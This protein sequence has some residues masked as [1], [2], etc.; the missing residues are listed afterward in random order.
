MKL[1]RRPNSADLRDCAVTI[2]S[3]DGV[4]RGHQALIT[5]VLEH[6]RQ[7]GL[8]AVMMSFEPLPREVV[9][10]ADPPARLTNFRERWRLL[11]HSTLDFLWLL[12]FT[13]VRGRSAEEFMQLLAAVRARVVVVGHDFRFGRG[14]E[15]DAQWCAAQAPRHGFEV[16]ILPPVLSEGV[17]ISSDGVRAA[18][19]NADFAAARELLGRPYVMR[20]RVRRGDQLGRQLGFPTANIAV[21]RRRLALSGIFAV[22]V[23]EGGHEGAAPPRP[24]VASLG[25]RP[26]IGGRVPLLEAHLFDFDGDLYGRELEIEFVAKL[27]EEQMFASMDAMVAQMHRDAQAARSVLGAGAAAIP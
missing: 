11:E 21:R 12:P 23:H 25:W 4:H 8:S 10:A 5:R 26:M 19:A 2:G 16:D 24:G 13:Q 27:R 9:R 7:L 20:G 1:L 6:A 15:R 3:F 18:L 22:R 14:G 17:R